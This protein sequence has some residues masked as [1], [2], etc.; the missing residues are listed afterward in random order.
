MKKFI[1]KQSD[2]D[3]N[4]FECIIDGSLSKDPELISESFNNYFTEIGPKL[5]VRFKKELHKCFIFLQT[6][7]TACFYLILMKMRYQQ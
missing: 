2:S 3:K 4:N 7:K 1:G 5:T 6:L